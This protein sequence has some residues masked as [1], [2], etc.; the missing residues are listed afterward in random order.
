MSNNLVIV[1]PVFNEAE[2][3][4]SFINEIR[5]NF[6]TIKP[7]I[8]TIDD[9]STD[10]TWSILST[11]KTQSNDLI[12]VRNQINLGH[13]QSTIRAFQ[14]GLLE[15]SKFIMSI[16]GDGQFLG[17]ELFKFYKEFCASNSIYGEGNRVYRQDPWFRRVIS[18]V[19]RLLILVKSGRRTI[20]ANT[21]ARIYKAETLQNL[22]EN[23]ESTSLVPNLRISIMVRK[24]RINIFTGNLT[25]IPR[26]AQSSQGSSWG[27]KK[28]FF[29]NKRLIK[30][31]NKAIKEFF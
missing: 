16:D 12:L 14:Q 24:K 20:D 27:S 25:N 9:C 29:P 18:L 26:R 1:M 3:I 30:F 5:V 10:E 31:C 7:T 2:G 15:K 6:K 28:T 17:E 8:V 21:P 11:M 23:F 4:E 19:T 22:I 13:G